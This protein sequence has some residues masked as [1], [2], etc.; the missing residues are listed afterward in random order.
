MKALV[1]TGTGPF[2]LQLAEV[3]DPTPG[4]SDVVIAVAAA[5]VNRGELG[6]A[7]T[8]PAGSRLGWDVAGTV[9]AGAADG[10]GPPVG[11]RV[12]ALVE[13]VGWASRVAVPARR[14]AVLPAEI[15]DEEA[16]A[17]PVAG[18]TALYGLRTAGWLLG[19]RILI[20]GAGGGVGR[21]AV[22]LAAYGGGDPI[23]LV[24]AAA[25]G[26]GLADLGAVQVATYTD[27]QTAAEAGSAGGAGGAGEPWA[28]V[29]VVLDSAGGTVLATALQLLAP[30]GVAVSIGNSSRAPLT[31]PFDW[32]YRRPGA[33]HHYL[34]LFDEA[35]RRDVGAD[36]ALLA[37]LAAAKR[38]DAQ[39]AVTRSWR[40]PEPALRALAERTV[41]GKVVFRID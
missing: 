19:Q 11:T 6:L 36:L 15:T 25:R 35:N 7:T 14:L 21:L 24:G 28:P 8:L 9:V 13:R 40:D 10:A 34:H 37:R 39:V 31:V 18:L 20:T 23:A 30:G 32:G 27:A 5:G 2:G 3:P 1:T 22:Q 26:Q 29:D 33:R 4:P 16:A 38:L 41:N 12:V 17:L